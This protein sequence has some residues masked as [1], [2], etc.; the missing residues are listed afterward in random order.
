MVPKEQSINHHAHISPQLPHGAR[1]PVVYP[2][3]AT[4]C[5]IES[6]DGEDFTS[7]QD[8]ITAIGNVATTYVINP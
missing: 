1:L 3:V 5:G 8:V 4:A 7:I 6:D 2:S